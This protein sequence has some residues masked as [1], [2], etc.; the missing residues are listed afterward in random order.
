MKTLQNII[1]SFTPI[2]FDLITKEILALN[3]KKACPKHSIPVKILKENYDIFGHKLKIDFKSA[4]TNGISP[5]NQKYADITPVF[6]SGDKNCKE[7][8]RPVSI[9]PTICLT[10]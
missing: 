10:R 2:N 1:F 5:D 4:I 7:N 8:Y 9:L 6:K 3:I